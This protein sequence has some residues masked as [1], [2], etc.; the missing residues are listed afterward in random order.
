MIA[1]RNAQ[2][3]VKKG[4]HLECYTCCPA[5]ANY[6]RMREPRTETPGLLG[7][8]IKDEASVLSSKELSVNLLFKKNER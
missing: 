3:D 8:Y 6:K 2:A 1:V 5:V 7:A 4:T